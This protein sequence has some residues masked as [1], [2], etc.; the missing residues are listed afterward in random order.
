MLKALHTHWRS[1]LPLPL[2]PN[3]L[4]EIFLVLFIPTNWRAAHGVRRLLTNNAGDFRVFNVFQI[5]TF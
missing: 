4:A 3:A 2:P 1:E 5:V